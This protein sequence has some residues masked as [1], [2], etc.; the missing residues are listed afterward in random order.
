MKKD[1][2]KFKNFIKNI[3]LFDHSSK[4]ERLIYIVVILWVVFGVL[5]IEFSSD[6]TQ[7]AGY[8]ASLSLFVGSYLWGE[9]KRSS[10]ET[11][12]FDKGINSPREVIIYITI[13]LWIILGLY[14]IIKQVNINT[15]TVYFSSLSPFVSSFII[16]K[17]TKGEERLPIFNGETKNLITTIID[18]ETTKEDSTGTMQTTTSSSTGT[19]QTTTSSTKVSSNDNTSD[20]GA[21][22]EGEANPDSYREPQ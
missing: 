17:T 16:Y 2:N 13:L 3:I 6:L 14:G 5:G 7:V 21:T 11:K 19:T 15:L 1:K 10:T 9:Y 12:L 18:K 22:S 4:S 20:D 8:Y